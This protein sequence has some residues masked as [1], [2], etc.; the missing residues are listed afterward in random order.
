MKSYFKEISRCC[1]ENQVPPGEVLK[2]EGESFVLGLR[3]K[4]WRVVD[5]VGLLV[6][7]ADDDCPIAFEDVF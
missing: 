1:F 4:G 5:V 2:D 7:G 6:C 3:G